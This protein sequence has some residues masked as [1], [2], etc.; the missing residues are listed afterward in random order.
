MVSTAKQLDAKAVALITGMDQP[1]GRTVGNALEVRESIE[2]LMGEVSPDLEEV[3]LSLG[4]EMMLLAGVAE[5]RE[6]ARAELI[7]L[8]REGEALRKFRQL[9]VIQGGDA[10]VVERPELLPQAP[11]Q[12]SLP[13]ERKGWVTGLDALEVGQIARD[14]GAGREKSGEK[15]DP[16]VGIAFQKRTGDRVEKGE[17]LAVIHAADAKTARSASERLAKAY[18][19]GPRQVKPPKIILGR[20]S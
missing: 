6:A 13:A 14:L 12:V 11:E 5:S 2:A 4:C 9:V 8:W 10:R 16:A 7:R 15:I 3:V 20:V 18:R 19:L 17:E 1:L